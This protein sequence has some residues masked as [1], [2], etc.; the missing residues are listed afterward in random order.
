MEAAN[1]KMCLWILTNNSHFLVCVA[2]QK[3]TE[4]EWIVEVSWKEKSA[5]NVIIFSLSK[6]YYELPKVDPSITLTDI[7]GSGLSGI[8]YRGWQNKKDV[9]V[10]VYTRVKGLY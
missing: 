5:V 3:G 8:V 7:P 6:L 10:K 4:F 2:F 1:L 9:V